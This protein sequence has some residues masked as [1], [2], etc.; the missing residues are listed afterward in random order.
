MLPSSPAPPLPSCK[1]AAIVGWGLFAS[2][3]FIGA[4]GDNFSDFFKAKLPLFC[5]TP[6]Q[7]VA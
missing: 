2:T 7:V 4:G 6:I 3:L 5:L 1:A